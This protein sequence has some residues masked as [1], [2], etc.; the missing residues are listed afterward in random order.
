[1]N[2]QARPPGDSS[3]RWSESVPRYSK[4]RSREYR[5]GLLIAARPLRRLPGRNEH[6]PTFTNPR[7]KVPAGSTQFELLNDSAT[8]VSQT[9]SKTLPTGGGTGKN[10]RLDIKITSDTKYYFL[11]I[12][13]GP[14]DDGG[15]KVTVNRLEWRGR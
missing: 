13:R 1:M 7:V 11:L 12:H 9:K 8:G 2:H 4:D 5:A 6:R 3:D 14:D 10:S 15:Y